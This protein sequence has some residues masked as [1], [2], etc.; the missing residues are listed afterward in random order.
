MQSNARPIESTPVT[1]L[2]PLSPEILRRL[3]AEHDLRL[4][5]R[6]SPVTPDQADT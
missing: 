3:R 1:G 4:N 2:F 6:E 5:A